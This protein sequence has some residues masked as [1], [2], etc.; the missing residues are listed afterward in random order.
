LEKL[1]RVSMPQYL[2]MDKQVQV[3]HSQWKAT[4]TNSQR[5]LIIL[6]LELGKLRWLKTISIMGYQFVL[7][8]MHLYRLK[9]AARANISLSHVLSYKST[10]RRYMIC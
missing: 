8:K 1:L 2:L 10:M 7:L 3:K 9:S 4:N 5:L 6:M